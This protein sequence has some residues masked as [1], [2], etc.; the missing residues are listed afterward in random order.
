MNSVLHR[1]ATCFELPSAYRCIH[2]VASCLMDENRRLIEALRL[3][4]LP[5]SG[6][7]LSGWSTRLGQLESPR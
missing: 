7:E 1:L 6:L 2:G 5:G 4:P 3:H